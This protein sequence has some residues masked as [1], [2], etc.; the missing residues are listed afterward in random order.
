MKFSII[1]PIKG[2]STYTESLFDSFH[3]HNTT[4]DFE[5][6]VINNGQD[7]ETKT[8][9]E[10]ESKK[11]PK[12]IVVENDKNIGVSA[13]W[14]QGIKK[15]T[16]EYICIINNDIEILTPS[17]LEC[18]K[19]T[20]DKS[21]TIYWTSPATCYDKDPKKI[22]FKPSHYE[23]LIYG[24][25]QYTYVVGCCF[26]CPRHCFDSIGLFDE[27]FDMRYY[28]DLD[29]INRILA[30]GNNVS[31]SNEVLIYHAVGVTSR[32]TAGGE[33]N[34]ALYQEKWGGTRTDILAQ[35]PPRIK[36]TKVFM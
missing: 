9:L 26:M 23:Q 1:M 8:L 13:S 32:N 19:K 27:K 18:F 24:T 36:A 11:I 29:Y 5:F 7:E 30:S 14:N 2:N 22:K 12:L 4:K 20:L 16:G 21:K 35:Q 25:D 15:S 6:I 28:E 17:W 10:K 3:R 31:M 34:A 33:N